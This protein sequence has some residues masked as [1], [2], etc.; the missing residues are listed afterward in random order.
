M[1]EL[2]FVLVFIEKT[3]ITIK[4]DKNHKTRITG[5]FGCYEK[6]ISPAINQ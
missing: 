6:T 4:S 1:K 5:F 3:E 2:E